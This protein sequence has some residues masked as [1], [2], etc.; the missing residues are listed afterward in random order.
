MVT[1]KDAGDAVTLL[2]SLAGSTFDSSQLVLTACMAYQNVKE[3]RLQE[4]RDK[5]RPSVK[6][7]LEERSKGIKAWKDSQGL[8]SKLYSFKKDPGSVIIASDKLEQRETEVNGDVSHADSSSVDEGDDEVDPVKDLKE[9]V[10]FTSLE[11]ILFYYSHVT[12]STTRMCRRKDIEFRRT[13][14]LSNLSC[15]LVCLYRRVVTSY[16]Q[17]N[18]SI[19]DFNQV[20]WLKVELCN[21]L[22]DKRS[23]ELR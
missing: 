19:I 21:L 10:Q 17:F 14:F 18:I 9:Q 23:A 5:H 3:T 6:A 13:V 11:S 2:Q 12:M 16:P 20:V 1:T 8:A 15:L 7:S 4:L 22:E